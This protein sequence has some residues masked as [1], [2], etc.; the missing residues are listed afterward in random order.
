MIKH[1]R[2]ITETIYDGIVVKTQNDIVSEQFTDKQY[3]LRDIIDGLSVITNGSTRK[4]EIEIC[5]DKQNRFK[6][7][8]RW[9]EQ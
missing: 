9:R 7:T 2:R 8:Q 5:L 1:G 4:L 6:L 3:L